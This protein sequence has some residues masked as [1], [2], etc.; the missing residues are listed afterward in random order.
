[1]TLTDGQTIRL[2]APT[3]GRVTGRVGRQVDA[4]VIRGVVETQTVRVHLDTLPGLRGGDPGA[5]QQL[6]GERLASDRT[7]GDVGRRYGVDR[8]IAGGGL[9]GLP[10]ALRG[11]LRRK[12]RVYRGLRDDHGVIGDVVLQRG[13]RASEVDVRHGQT[14]HGD[15]RAVDLADD[16]VPRRPHGCRVR[17][18]PLLRDAVRVQ[19]RLPADQERADT[20]RPGRRLWGDRHLRFRTAAR[21]QRVRVDHGAVQ[22]GRL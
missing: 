10:N 5:E 4:E 6:A 18:V 16:R 13:V 17:D 3:E 2:D 14:P 21:R 12:R 11:G 7:G 20:A 15:L 19:D 8:K 9:H 1:R 22:H